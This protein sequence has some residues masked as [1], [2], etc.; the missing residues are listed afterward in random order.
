MPDEK[1]FQ[2]LVQ[3]SQ[4]EE[5][6]HNAFWRQLTPLKVL[7][8]VITLCLCIL[9]IVCTIRMILAPMPLDLSKIDLSKLDYKDALNLV[10][11]LFAIWLSVSF[12]HRASDS[13]NKFYDRVYN[14]TKDTSTLLGAL[15]AG[16]GEQLKQLPNSIL[17][18]LL[19]MKE[20]G[21]E[22]IK[23]ANQDLTVLR[24]QS[25][26]LRQEFSK[27]S[28]LDQ[29]SKERYEATL[30]EYSQKIGATQEGLA[31][32]AERISEA[33]MASQLPPHSVQYI[34]TKIL[35]N[36][37]TILATETDDGEVPT[38]LQAAWKGMVKRI[39][40]PILDDL[41]AAGFAT[42]HRELTPAGARLLQRIGAS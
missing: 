23:K 38:T 16:F 17:Q 25:E 22:D 30:Q 7:Q 14:F 28:Q 19:L 15:Q 36:L 1:G 21:I 18:N 32:A 3:Y 4:P 11:A 12:Y 34:L 24:S 29:P 35:P 37:E 9:V 41:G 2:T 8:W 5:Q 6:R 10:L 39:P 26:E 33:D 13:S 40:R 27:L 31:R 20:Q 42:P